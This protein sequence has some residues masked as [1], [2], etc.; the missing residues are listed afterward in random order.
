MHPKIQAFF[1]E[2][3]APRH[4][5]KAVVHASLQPVAK[6]VADVQKQMIEYHALL[7]DIELADDNDHA[8]DP[9]LEHFRQ[10]LGAVDREVAILAAS[11]RN[12]AR[13]FVQLDRY[14]ATAKTDVARFEAE[15]AAAPVVPDG[16]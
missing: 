5:S 2:H 6:T 7:S 11:A 9:K 14:M 4:A 1:D 3:E 13:A 12:V 10:T 16:E 15:R 8:L